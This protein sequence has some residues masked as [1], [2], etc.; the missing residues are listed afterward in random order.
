MQSQFHQ[1]QF[2]TTYASITMI[3]HFPKFYLM[4][5]N[6]KNQIKLKL[7]FKIGKIIHDIL[8]KKIFKK[9]IWFKW[10]HMFSV[11]TKIGNGRTSHCSSNNIQR[12]VNLT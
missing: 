11:I 5:L 8:G 1:N 10:L 4:Q 3:Q 12:E 9:K 6:Q 2:Q 7:N